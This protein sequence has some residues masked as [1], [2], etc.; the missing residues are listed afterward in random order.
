MGRLGSAFELLGKALRKPPHVV[1]ARGV[2]EAR[3]VLESYE[4]P[5][6]GSGLS[7]AGMLDDLQASSINVLWE[8]LRTRPYPALTTRIDAGTLDAICPGES[9]IVFERAER[10]LEHRV[11]L[12]GSGLVSLG[13]EIDWHRDFKSGARWTPDYYGRIRY[14]DPTAAS[15]VKVPWELSRLQWLIPAGQAYL[16]G[17]DERYAVGAR[18]ILQHWIE[19]NPYGCSVNWTCTMEVALRIF[20]WTWLFHAFAGSAAWHDAT[21]RQQ[22][23]EMLYAHGHFTARHVERSDING[24]HYTAD[25][26]GLVFAGLFFGG[27]GRSKDWARDGWRMLVDDL[28]RQVHPDGV[29]FEASS[30]YHRLVFELFWLSARY[31]QRSG[32]PVD[33]IYLERMTKMARFTA[34]YSRNDGT[35]PL[36]GDADD[37]RALPFG[38]QPINDHRYVVGLVSAASNAGDLVAA[39]SGPRAEILWLLGPDAAGRLPNRDCAADAAVSTAFSHGG[40]YVMRTRDDHIFIDCGPVGLGGRGGHGHNDCLSFSATLNGVPLVTD[41]GSYL[42]TSSYEERNRFRSTAFHNTP[43]VDDAELNRFISPMHLWN[44][45]DDAQPAVRR[46]DSGPDRDVFVGS[47]TG[48]QR[49]A[50]PVAPVR[51]IVLDKRQSRLLVIDELTG[52]GVHD[53]SIPLHL[54]PGV[55]AVASGDVIH[56]TRGAD[57]FALRWWGESWALTVGEGRVAPTYGRVEPIVR[58][59]WRRRAEGGRLAMTIARDDASSS[60]DAVQELA[61]AAGI[62]GWSD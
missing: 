22:F 25:A 58:L 61:R 41:C 20:T 9:A 13:D 50:E 30:A 16:L 10:A 4:I 47:H 32:H 18:A 34:A 12:L 37:A 53:V 14:G 8:A 56:L 43:Q 35:S 5:R 17:G 21:F 2:A 28:P 62:T 3:R 33:A 7:L 59:V 57:V 19:Q 52:S 26:A 48:Y 27:N 55:S 6:R 15:D 60:F 39:F 42:Y 49:L 23:V 29:D 36:W 11:D 45:H 40:C 38:S 46:W 54:A 1:W 24:N 44:L 31:R 51:T